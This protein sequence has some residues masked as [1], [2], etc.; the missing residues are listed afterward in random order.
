MI[1][2]GIVGLGRMGHAFGV[3]PAGDPLSHS[4]AFA[5][6]PDV[7]LAV[8]VDPHEGARAAFLAR[9][10]D[11]RCFPAPAAAPPD[12]SLDVVVVASPTTGHAADIGAALRW[13]PR[14]ILAEKPLAPSA[15]SAEQVARR[16][17]EARCLLLVNYTRRFTPMLATLRRVVAADGPV[18]RPRGACLRYSGG[19]VHNGT[20]W[21]DLLSALCGPPAGAAAARGLEA[22]P[23]GESAGPPTIVL[24]WPDGLRASLVPARGASWSVGEGELWS[25]SGLVRFSDGG[26]RVT[27]QRPRAA[28][29]P[30]FRALGPEEPLCGDGLA[31]HVAGAAREAIR[32]ATSGGEPLCTAEDAIR[33]LRIAEPFELGG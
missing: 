28:D 33:A 7:V 2:V 10:P 25:E 14:V 6:E 5:R 23:D 22:E 4:E 3:S 18:G 11:A 13:R 12:M 19:L 29:W 17:A 21:I 9:F 24:R 20:H 16:C 32:L 30:G 15:A 8:G 27:L 1:R 31:G 26:R